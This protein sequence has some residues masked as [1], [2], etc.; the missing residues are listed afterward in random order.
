[1]N[2]TCVVQAGVKDDSLELMERFPGPL[3]SSISRDKVSPAL[4]TRNPYA[5]GSS[6]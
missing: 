4:K 6:L 3:T 5:N 1:V 2:G